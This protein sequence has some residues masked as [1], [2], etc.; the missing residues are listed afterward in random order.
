MPKYTDMLQLCAADPLPG[1]ALGAPL[2]RAPARP[3][4]PAWAPVA[5][6]PHLWQSPAGALAYRPPEPAKPQP[7]KPLEDAAN[8]LIKDTL[9]GTVDPFGPLR[10]LPTGLYIVEHLHNGKHKPYARYWDP[11]KEH[12]S[13]AISVNTPMYDQHVSQARRKLKA[14]SLESAP[15]VRVIDT[16]GVTHFAY[17]ALKH[18][19]ML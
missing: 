17:R 9:A 16:L 14:E 7:A 6:R 4:A 19:G 1:L 10:G 2:P 8:Q 11:A 3:V 5:G 15:V 13:Y 12:L 18:V